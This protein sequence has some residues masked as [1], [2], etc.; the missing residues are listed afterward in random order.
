MAKKCFGTA[1]SLLLCLALAAQAVAA[2]RTVPAA[3]GGAAV[4]SLPAAAE[5]GAEEHMFVSVGGMQNLQGLLDVGDDYG[6]GFG[7]NGASVFI[8]VTGRLG[9][10]RPGA[11]WRT[12]EGSPA[13]E[14]PAASVLED[15]SAAT[16][17][18]A[19]WEVGM[20][21][22]APAASC[23]EYVVVAEL[24]RAPPVMHI[25]TSPC[26]LVDAWWIALV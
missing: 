11:A 22:E 7:Y 5:S 9:G 15:S 4:A 1:A 6:G 2:A 16:A 26:S 24:P 8:S 17:C 18:S 20:A 12:A 21:V 3:A 10:V 19:G 25:C 23:L 13:L 14:E